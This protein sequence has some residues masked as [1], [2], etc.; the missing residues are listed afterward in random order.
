[1]YFPRSSY[2]TFCM[3]RLVTLSKLPL[4]VIRMSSLL[5]M[6]LLSLYHITT[7]VGMDSPVHDSC[8]VRSSISVVISGKLFNSEGRA[9][10]KINK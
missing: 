5:M 4:V 7:G 8:T 9:A 6:V 2:L 1:M 3:V 10:T